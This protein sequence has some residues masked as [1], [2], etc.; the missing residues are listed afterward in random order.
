MLDRLTADGLTY[1]QDGATWLRSEDL[2]DQR[3]RVLV[4]SD[5]NTTYL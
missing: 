5:G 1:E 4:K 2:G 3:D